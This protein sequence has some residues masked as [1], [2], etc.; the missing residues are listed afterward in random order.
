MNAFP[1]ACCTSTHNR[2]RN[3]HS[4]FELVQLFILLLRWR[5]LEKGVGGTEAAIEGRQRESWCFLGEKKALK[6][7]Y[8]CAQW[9][10]SA[11]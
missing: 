4:R 3:S 2:N 7:E 9:Q 5:K 11:P 6:M 10:E 8:V 1:P